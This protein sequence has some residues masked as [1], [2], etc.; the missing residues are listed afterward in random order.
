MSNGQPYHIHAPHAN[1]NIY[2]DAP[3]SHRISASFTGQGGQYGVP[4]II[5]GERTA[6]NMSIRTNGRV[7]N[8]A[9][10]YGGTFTANTNLNYI[11]GY[12]GLSSTGNIG[13]A[14]VI[15]YRDA[16]ALTGTDVQK[17][18]SYLALKYGITLDQSSGQHYLAS[19]GSKMWDATVN[20]NY[21]N[22][23]AGL[24]RDNCQLLHQ[25]QSKSSNPAQFITIGVGSSIA[26]SNPA[27]TG[28]VSNDKS[29]LVW[30]DNGTP[31]NTVVAVSGVNVTER[32]SRVWRV[33]KTNWAD[34][35]I[36]FQA[37]GYANRYLLIHNSSATFATPPTQEIL[38][39][40]TGS[41]TFN[42]SLLP[43]GAYFSFGSVFQGP[44]CVNVGIGGW[45][46]ADQFCSGMEWKDYSGNDHT[47]TANGVPAFNT[48]GANFNPLV[49][50]N[51]NNYQYTDG[52]FKNAPGIVNS[53]VFTVVVPVSGQYTEPWGEYTTN[54]NNYHIHG[55][56]AN[57][58]IYHDAPYGYRI[59][60]GFVAQGGQFG[61]PNIIA[62]ERTQNNM[63]IRTN[64]KVLNQA[65]S[66]TGSFISHTNLNFLGASY[67]L[68]S[69]GNS[70]VAE[71]I[72]YRDA[73]N[74]TA[75][76]VQKIESYLALKY[77][78]TLDQ[79]TP[80]D[81]LAGDGTTKM[82]DAT[83][84]AAFKYN[85][86]GLGRDNCQLLH[87]KQSQ[88][89][90]SGQFI[91][92]ALGD[93]IAA[94]NGNHPQTIT[95]DKSFLVWGDNNSSRF[96]SVAIT[97]SSNVTGRMARVWRVDKTNWADQNITIKAAGYPNRY[98]LI[99]LTSSTFATAPS[100]EILLDGTGSA[101]FSSSLL[102][103]GAYFTIGDA[104]KGPGCV[105]AGIGAWWKADYQMG[106]TYWNDYSG[107][108]KNAYNQ[109][110]PVPQT[111]GA[112]YNPFVKFF[113][114][115]YRYDE[116]VFKDA[117]GIV[118]TKLFTVVI[119]IAGQYSEPWGE[120]MSN[121]QPYHIHAPHANANIY[122]DAPYGHR[123][124][125][126]FAAMGGQYDVP[127][128]IAGERTQTNM[129]I[130]TNGKVVN[131]PGSYT[132][133]FT[134]NT[135]LN[136]IGAYN[137][138]AS[139]GGCGLA[140]VIVYRDASTLTA[141]D[142]QKIESYLALKYGITLDQTT[143]RDYL[144]GDGTTKMWDATA[145]AAFK[146]N[147][148]GM[149][150]DLCQQLH[151]KQSKS[152]NPKQF[153]TFALGDSIAASNGNNVKSVTNDKSFF[154]WADDNGSRFTSAAVTASNVTQRMTRVWKVDKTNWADQTITFKAIGYP[155][156]YLLIHN[157]SA[158]FASA[159]TQE[160][161]LDGNGA[162][163]F[164]SSLLPDGA[165]FTIGDAILGPGCV[166]AG[167]G[168]WWKADYDMNATHWS[169]Y[170]GNDKYTTA[171]G[172]PTPLVSGANFNPMV[173]FNGNH[174][175]YTGN[176]IFEN[177]I[178]AVN[179]RVFVVSIPVN[180]QYTAAW[181][182][183]QNNGQNMQLL[184]PWSD[185]TIYHDAPYGNRVQQ[186][187]STQGG[188]YD[189]PN[190]VVGIR[191]ASNMA[192]RLQGKQIVNNN[193]NYS[194]GYTTT[195]W[196]HLGAVP[197]TASSG[198]T[199]L[200]E[201]IVYRDA[202]N[203]TPTDLQKV[204]SYLAL[205]YG[206]TLD[207]TTPR[208]YLAADGTTKMWDATSN[209]TYRYNIAGMGKDRC[210]QLH[211]KQSRS[212]NP[213][214]FVAFSL[215]SNIPVSNATNLESVTNDKS[216]FTWGDDNGQLQSSISVNASTVSERSGR[217]WRVDKTN[218][219]DQTIT[220]KAQGYPNRALLISNTDPT[221]SGV[222][223]QEI[224]LDGTGSATFS[225]SLLPDGAYFTLGNVLIG[226]GNVN[227]GV[228]SWF[229]A[230]E[231]DEGIM[232]NG[233][234][235]TDKSGWHRDMSQIN[236]NSDP[237]VVQSMVN[238]NKGAF[239]DGDDVVY[240]PSYGTAF[241][242][243]EVFAVG[244]TYDV[245]GRG[246]MFDFGGT[247]NSPSHYTW[248]NGGVYE[249]FGTDIRVGFNPTDNTVYE[250]PPGLTVSGAPYKGTDWNV[251][252][253]GSAPNSWFAGFNGLVKAT[254]T[255]N[256]PTFTGNGNMHIGYRGGYYN[257]G[258]IAEVIHYN[259][260][261]TAPERQKVHSYLALKYGITLDQTSPYNYVATNGTVYWDA[262][263]NSAFK[264]NIA[265]VGRD[266]FTNLNQ[267][268]SKSVNAGQFITM[269]VG[270]E[271]AASNL[272]NASVI[273][274]D[275]SYFVW[276]DNN[277]STS[278][279]VAV[280]A[281][282]V[283][284]RMARIWRVDKTA[285]WADQNITF[286]A[287]GYPNR[288]LIVHNTSA[289]FATAPDQEIL[290]DTLGRATFNTS[291]LPDGAYFTI[292]DAIKG[293]GCVNLG[294]KLWLRADQGSVTP[295]SWPDYSGN[296]NTPVGRGAA[297]I[298]TGNA[299]NYNP[300]VV[301]SGATTNE[302]YD[303]QSDLF[304][305]GNHSIS[306]FSVGTG[307]GGT[308]LSH[309]GQATN[310]AVY[311]R[312]TSPTAY[313]DF[314]ANGFSRPTIPATTRIMRNVYT[315]GTAIRGISFNGNAT[316]N[317]AAS[318]LNWQ[319]GGLGTRILG[320]D[321]AS[322]AFKYTGNLPEMIVYF[323]VDLTPQQVQRIESY[324]ALKYGITLDQTTPRDYLAGDATTKMWDATVNAAYKFNIAGLGRDNC[325]V[326]NQKQSASANAG[327]FITMAVGDSI[328]TS[329]ATNTAIIN[330]NNSFLVW[331]DDNGSQT[332]TVA[333]T[334]T[335]VTERMTRVFRVDKTNWA[336]Q[337]ITFKATGYGNRYLIISNSSATFTTVN[338]EIL[339]DAS[340]KATFNSS[341]L[342]DGAY[343]T[344]GD[345]LKGP[346]CVNLGIKLWLRA[347]FDASVGAWDDYSG[348][349][350]SA[351]QATLANQPV[352]SSG[353]LN[354]NPALVFD[355]SN[356]NL[357]IANAGL[358]GL[359]TGNG[360]RTAFFVGKL[361]TNTGQ[362]FA[363]AY[364]S[365]AVSQSFNM[366]NDAGRAWY[367]SWGTGYYG[368]TGAFPAQ[369]TI[370]NAWNHN[371]SVNP[372]SKGYIDGKQDWSFNTTMNTVIGAN[373]FYIGRHNDNA[374]PRYWD[375]SIGEVILY[376]RSLTAAEMQRVNSYL[377]IKYGITMDQTT[378][379]DYM[380]GDGSTKMWDAAVNTG[381]TNDIAGIGRDNCQALYQKQS[382]SV[383]ADDIVAMGLGGIAADNA[384]NTG[385]LSDKT[386]LVWANNNG[387][388]TWQT[389]ESPISRVR[390]S[391]EWKIDETGTVGTMKIQVPDNSSSLIGKLP[392]EVNGSIYLLV[393]AD[394]DFSSGA[395]SVTMTLNG[396]VWETDYDFSDGQ[397]FTFATQLPAA[398]GCV[399]DNLNL[400][401]KANA[402]TS[403]TT[404]NDVLDLWADQTPNG[405][406]A[407]Q[408]TV[409]EKP[410]YQS[411]SINLFNFNSTIGFSG[412]K[413]FVNTT[414]PVMDKNAYTIFSVL[415]RNVAVNYSG[416]FS[417]N[418][419]GNAGQPATTYLTTT[420]SIGINAVNQGPTGVFVTDP[421]T[422]Q[423]LLRN[424]GNAG[425]VNMVMN[426]GTP[427]A[428][429]AYPGTPAGT[430]TG[431]YVGRHNT[432]LNLTLNGNIAELAVYKTGALTTAQVNAIESYFAVKYGLMLG[433]DYVSGGNATIWDIGATGGYDSRVFG[434]GRDDCQALLQKQSKSAVNGALVTLGNGNLIVG[435]NAE[436]SSV[437][438]ADA[439][440]LLAGDNNGA[441]AWQLAE[442][443]ANRQRLSREWRVY[444]TGTVGS[445]KIRVPDNSSSAT[446]KLPGEV[447]TVYLLTDAD[448]DFSS[449][450][451][452]TA[453]SLN[454]TDW[455]A[456]IDLTNG[457]Y[458][459]FATNVPAAPGCEVSNLSLWLKA[460][461]GV[462]GAPTVTGWTDQSS[463]ANL[464]TVVGAPQITS[465]INFNPA[466]V[467]AA[468][469]YF[470]TPNA[471]QL[472]PTSS[473]V[474]VFGVTRPTVLGFN[475]VIAKTDD[476]GW[477]NGYGM[478][479]NSN[480]KIGFWEGDQSGTE[481]ANVPHQPY[482][483]T[484]FLATGYYD[485]NQKV[486]VNGAAATS[487]T[488]TP[489]L[490]TS[491][492]EIGYAKTFQFIGDYAEVILYNNDVGANARDRIETYL[493]LKYGITM[494]HD[495]LSGSNVTIWDIGATGGY[496]NDI[497]GIGRDDC[498]GLE[499]RQSKSVNTDALITMG[500]GNTIATTNTANASAFSAD[501]SFMLWGNNNGAIAWQ[502]TEAPSGR[503]RLTREWKIAETGTVGSVKIR[504]PD[505][506][507][508]LASKLPAK[509][510]TIFLLVDDD[511]DFSSGAT[512]IPL[513]A[514]G[515][516]WDVD[517]DLLD[518]QYI[519][520]ATETCNPLITGNPVDVAVC[521]GSNATFN[522][523]G[524]GSGLTYQ[525]QESTN[526]GGTF[527]NIAGAT[528]ASYT[529]S[530]V[531]GAMDGYQYR[532]VVSNGCPPAATSTAATMTVNT[533]PVISGQPAN[534]SVCDGT[535]ATF[536]V[537]ANGSGL[538]LQWQESTDGG[539]NYTNLSGETAPNLTFTAIGAMNG[540]KYR[541]V[542]TGTCTPVVTS[543]A[544]IL[545]VN[546]PPTITTQPTNDTIC[547]G[548]NAIFTVAATGTNL[549]YQW[550][551]NTGSGFVN[552]AGATSASYTKT[553]TTGAM[554]GYQY[555]VIVSGDCPLPV[556]SNSVMLTVNTL[557]AIT[558]QPTAQTVCAGV[559]A[560]FTVVATGT[561]IIY[562]WQESTNGGGTFTNI[563]GA[564]SATYTKTA[565]T[566]AMS[567]YQYRVIVSGTCTPA[568]TSSAMALTVNTA[569]AI[570]T[571]PSAATVCASVNAAFSVSA[572]GTSLTYQWQENTGSGF[573]N[574]VGATSASYTK[575]GTTGAMSGYQYQV[576]VT[577][578]C[579]APVTSSPVTL[580]VNT[581]PAITI[582][583]SAVTVC[584][585]TDATFSVT[586]SGTGLSYQW[587]ESTNGGGSFSNISGAT[588]AAYTK[589]G[590]TGA[591]NGYQ[592]RVIVSGTC[593]PPVTSAAVTLTVNTA[594]G[595]TSQPTAQVVCA[596]QN[597]T[598]SVT[599]SGT[600]PSY[601][602]QEN[603]GSGF[604]N[605][606]GATSASY[607][608]AST[609]VAMSGYQ[610]QVVIT[611]ICPSPVT[612]SAVGLTVNALPSIISQP[613][614]QTVCAGQTSTFTVAASGTG[615]T[616]QWELNT[617]AGWNTISGATSV[618]FTTA[619]TTTG[620]S[621]N[622]Y[623][624]VVTGTCMPT[625]TS[626]I[627][628]LTVNALP[629][630]TSQPTAQTVCAG[631]DATFTISATG[632]GLTYQWQEN[633][634]SGFVD[635]PGATS[636][637]YTKNATTSAMSGNL[638]QV[639]ISGT[640]TPALISSAVV[641]TVNTAPGIT[642]QPAA[643]TVCAGVNATFTVTATGT[644]VTYQW[645]ENTGSGFVNIAGAT[646]AA[647][648][649]MT[650]AMAMNGYQY[651][652][653]VTGTCPTPV[654][655]SIVTL[656]VNALPAITT[657]P[658]A[659]TACAGENANFTVVAT[660]T[661]LTYQWQESTDGGTNFSNLAGETNASFVNMAVTSAM[662]G[663]Q[664]RVIVSGTCTPAITS[665]AVALT[666]N[667]SPSI[668]SQ[669]NS[670]T[671]CAGQNAIF[672]VAATGTF[673]TYQ[674]QENTGS[675]FINIAGATNPSYTKSS[676]TTA[677]S[678]YQ[679]RVVLN[680]PC[681]PLNSD[682]V[683]LTVNTAPAITGQ[684]A[685]V[686]VCNGVDATFGATATGTGLTYQ[687][688]ESTNGGASFSNIPG[689]TASAFTKNST[690]TAMNGYQYRVVVTGVCT[691]AVTSNMVTLTV[692]ALPAIT[693]QPNST[694][695]CAGN[696]AIF[697]VTATGSGL[698]YQWQEN[699]GSGFV[700]I[701]GATASIF[702]K[703][704]VTTA[705]SSY[706][707]RVI[708]SGTC[709]P[710]VTSNA[711]NLT[712]NAVPSVTTQP[713]SVITC[714]GA[715]VI[716]SVTAT[717]NGLT[718][719]WQE[720][721]GSG[722]VDISGATTN[723]YTKTGITNAMSGYEYQ[724]V[725]SGAC[726]PPATSNPATLTVTTAPVITS[727]PVDLSVCSGANAIF[728]VTASGTG[729][730]YQWQV[731]DGLGWVD[732][733]GA[734][735]ASYTKVGV[736]ISYNGYQYRVM[737]GG[738]C[739]PVLI[740]S[741]AT[742]TI[743]QGPGI[744][745]QPT[746]L[747]ACVASNASFSVTATGPG[748]TYQWQ[749]NTGSGF[750]NISGANSDSYTKS[751]VNNSMNGYLYRV[752]VTGICAPTIISN[753]AT[754][755]VEAPP[756]IS[757]QPANAATCV[758]NDATFSVTATG[759]GLT[760]QWQENPGSGWVNIPGETAANLNRVAVTSSM[761]GYQYRVLVTG[762]CSPPA[763]SN[764]ATLTVNISPAITTQPADVA[765]C[766]GVNAL[767]SV[768]ATGSGLSY[769]WQESTNGGGS[770]SNIAGATSSSYTKTGVIGAMNN[771]QYRVIVS[772][773]CTPAV[774]SNPAILTV[775]TA[776]A[777]VTQPSS[778][779]DLHWR[780]CYF[781]SNDHR[782]RFDLPM[783]GK[784]RL[785]FCEHSGRH[786]RYLYQNRHYSRYE[787]LYL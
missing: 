450:S 764:A 73:T 15:V 106:A 67:G 83:A 342:P 503:Q 243:G 96:T 135:N 729:I 424:T 181:G 207:Q 214:Q 2:H 266:N 534:L 459:T 553:G 20:A 538:T 152:V 498:S 57:G 371:S 481:P 628:A 439:S 537:M 611:G 116:G 464:I 100:Q 210:Q 478:Y 71:V 92:F 627:V 441:N 144:A 513:A 569:P 124:Q 245:S 136:Y 315:A 349:D 183:R 554:N 316:T 567:G 662:S 6:T 527:T 166:N 500:N 494:S 570:I 667:V 507:S 541:V 303:F 396:T 598:F 282:N 757:S 108:D 376:D 234:G 702:I 738:A 125:A 676:T 334:A 719:Q 273:T 11:G 779:D 499:Q 47:A 606:P 410:S 585:G 525:W 379:T 562:Q 435:N 474:T 518:G 127:N 80:R 649:K 437:F 550:Q 45:W 728:S 457:Q 449:G 559:D 692:N 432:D 555:Q 132:G 270:A 244:Q 420:S 180:G 269:A 247:G 544:A 587:Q 722:F 36:T 382:K 313:F 782:L 579:P 51:G 218:W 765:G 731:N 458:F 583:P 392:G 417:Q 177:P 652:V 471:A 767:F 145:A 644:G 677:M 389:S 77:G 564:T 456:N 227:V 490:S 159:P 75:M 163:T 493:A 189:V 739:P 201:V 416:V 401:L 324:L 682:V 381:Y 747:T 154:T 251:F 393:D 763:T 487:A 465:A 294:V 645:Q 284:E 290:L 184:A 336:D 151:Q 110:A 497:V 584:A 278:V 31:I 551:Q 774:T 768:V 515:T 699:M 489:T 771:N 599:A 751:G 404:D 307:T 444:E 745:S 164:N 363:L 262:T 312:T 427:N 479:T 328:A 56:H 332:T 285:N 545:T 252:N 655:S 524:F 204:E 504:V 666:V 488:Q 197:G 13:V 521:A 656:T 377:A 345:A 196:S 288:Y 248:V 742:L 306:V 659:Q 62:G 220:F 175:D 605:I 741:V 619:A 690:T 673:L 686:T 691:P 670:Q 557:P 297:I 783:A 275:R 367:E 280:T 712:V 517:Y 726:A 198:G 409:A 174:Y 463:Y 529:K 239:F 639:I 385:T 451:I 333:V 615:V 102:P 190:L 242:Q 33:D 576:I 18:E 709:A 470:T 787:R 111:T 658:T 293:P 486:S 185:N 140:E 744:T 173:K 608:K 34:Q 760:Y 640:C 772:G 632:A 762:G 588:T 224:V 351:V 115:H 114:N 384:S 454:G 84:N 510:S 217:I 428:T 281:A 339:L 238:F 330:N 350:R 86:A 531:T 107:N 617:G 601:Q 485:T 229:D 654:T 338:Q 522:V 250:N 193:A 448:G 590:T 455:E 422:G 552:I 453:M 405:Y 299:V 155:N 648:T 406:D 358:T 200:A 323:D 355:N 374:G 182:E 89:V 60:A 661:G 147:I 516:D 781:R 582:Q 407:T 7:L 354:F 696:N 434:I 754:M 609:T 653:V 533:P 271:I 340:G 391:R 8:Q 440:F 671:V 777:I 720:N 775:N 380:S 727:Q 59:Q 26:A 206:I 101:T 160:I 626:N 710:S 259:R 4:N 660:G 314:Y 104:L 277:A 766:V 139:S 268:Q 705:M 5:A 370:I 680:G 735:N 460:N 466:I 687:W 753:T 614:P 118:N 225:S 12:Y 119:P 724:V 88:S 593:T 346:G 399:V 112:N 621:G 520:F 211:Q 93:S 623:R 736:P 176:G 79:T 283:T 761:N 784:H 447:S 246:P 205:K 476:A 415:K 301:F 195:V 42:S 117:P 472:N 629:A 780:K 704:S 236:P 171:V 689:A 327:Q 375:G 403:S 170:S 194:T 675:G 70:G 717:G 714:E 263:V 157:T 603:T 162:A 91:T 631:A 748:L 600:G 9:A 622:Q 730:A 412:L 506:T 310:Q 637:S 53:K 734:T 502:T 58:N 50:F 630:I 126:G 65:G 681:V 149:G 624:V 505:N 572:T 82:W 697:S 716:F 348:N 616:Y 580:T 756:S 484:T 158:T 426:G 137:G 153:I 156:R 769:Q 360:S 563:S 501:K 483:S 359:P 257:Y 295:T 707:Y 414:M 618:S 546:A 612:S 25:K 445:V 347:D 212:V 436:N 743:T 713:V 326:L 495:Y 90:N 221:F 526:G 647:Y 130:R 688:Q 85:L 548:Q 267:K 711:A 397:Y 718:Y 179:T 530:S 785:W 723:S 592:Y 69:S 473:K 633:T 216:F 469:K 209:A 32:M 235:W 274:N 103:D 511:G 430:T 54:A 586:A 715:N 773:T 61:V 657:Q 419:S 169:D 372:S 258:R 105:N 732:I 594:P 308:I 539:A 41:A 305:S 496:D 254:R 63:S 298:N 778:P 411:D 365:G 46:R 366:G 28:T 129:S 230:S 241:T 222:P 95:N 542:I 725:V 150:K 369:R 388:I 669:P 81:Y 638:Y 264:Y 390:L 276:G 148:A 776:P 413:D 770:F 589:T 740:S 574:I 16:S 356:D 226:P 678:G 536:G 492:V 634:G 261:L 664:Y 446:T 219:A 167:V 568:V 543:N 642:S 595:I 708:I 87:Q 695:L 146:Y 272:A 142:V 133:T 29:F 613:T 565:T 556:T 265:G 386:F 138:L 597:A 256:T 549:T 604:V 123:I 668:N 721:A 27:N 10:N 113:S 289:T 394:G 68:S 134:A 362:D 602:W 120:W 636:V 352:L 321:L 78:I 191:T 560:T 423:F 679:Y 651:R 701:P 228:S 109:G 240:Q 477:S 610:Y 532:A 685:N 44:G 373:P 38:L 620:M 302:A 74:M 168:A 577:G 317:S 475:P 387:A 322:G 467:L 635:I 759:T 128:I 66:Y 591:M 23:I 186:T 438:S 421:L 141:T 480:Q 296:D 575:T 566:S 292:G 309:G 279:P 643:A 468:G 341:L 684:P 746:S 641:L 540:R 625:L 17:I 364:G 700:N 698:S 514:N 208:D 237:E 491:Q 161:A 383:N 213:N 443:P 733:P 646:S 37:T 215:G 547:A 199:G 72:V 509:T 21:A 400:W 344:I 143:P 337:N 311:V 398:P 253:V 433:H 578:T 260:K 452:E 24:G 319:P 121:G 361:N 694:T 683:L 368:V 663:R 755:L 300:S 249:S 596:G 674:W 1:G 558:T 255:I 758:G 39:D 320:H 750:I 519:T 3:Y 418:M 512:E 30:G 223:D 706:Q 508:A 202:T 343:F 76:D 573:V 55:P 528:S 535:V 48:T 203:F 192:I 187:F 286:K 353:A 425:N 737:V 672:T 749:E 693:A 408:T 650:T 165:Y 98:L 94:S 329:N 233:A 402:G 581:L 232:V 14:E 99:H 331:G 19:D 97:G 231:M 378:P 561:G 325:D 291:L 571:Q 49:K 429:G 442:T 786:E 703:A 335:N 752:L 357:Q 395:S 122:H 318:A 523:T 22:N 462:T 178:T 665:T 35:T 287:Q 482:P 304:T 188:N 607:T 43:D 431:Y 52:V 131:Q 64:G 40:G 461:A 172:V